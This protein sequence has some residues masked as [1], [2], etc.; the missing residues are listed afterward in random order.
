MLPARH[1]DADDDE[2]TQERMIIGIFY[3]DSSFGDVFKA[4]ICISQIPTSV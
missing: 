2:K 1:D 4:L 3:R